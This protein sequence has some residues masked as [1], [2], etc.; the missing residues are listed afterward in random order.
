M[1]IAGAI[2]LIGGYTV[3]PKGEEVSTPEIWRFSPGTGRFQ[4]ETSMP[5]PVD[6]TVR[7]WFAASGAAGEFLELEFPA[8]VSVTELRV[9]NPS[10]TPGGFGSSLPMASTAMFCVKFSATP[11]PVRPAA[12]RPSASI[13]DLGRR[14]GSRFLALRAFFSGV[15]ASGPLMEKE[16]S[17]LATTSGMPARSGDLIRP[18]LFATREDTAAYCAER[19]LPWRE[20]A[21]NAASKRGLIRADLH[22]AYLDL[23]ERG[24]RQPTLAAATSLAEAL[25]LSLSSLVAAAERS[26]EVTNTS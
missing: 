8:D 13:I 22:P 9:S 26:P 2:F 23:L 3:S 15:A 17:W 6:D 16:P 7:N 21:S 24:A 10:A 20:D 12:P 4:I 11:L 25:G 1:T 14:G 5:T 18:L 19:G